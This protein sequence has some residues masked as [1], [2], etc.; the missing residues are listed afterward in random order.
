MCQKPFYEWNIGYYIEQSYNT[1][2]KLRITG[3]TTQN[4]NIVNLCVPGQLSRNLRPSFSS[5]ISCCCFCC[6]FRCGR[7]Y[8]WTGI[9][10]GPSVHSPGEMMLIGENKKTTWR[11]F[12]PSATLSTINPTWTDRGANPDHRGERPATNRLRQF[13]SLCIFPP[14]QF[15]F[16]F[17][18]NVFCL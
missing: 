3:V 15:Y 7:L 13:Q 14:T 12:Y 10:N 16:L 6:S 4:N 17:V 8:L 11:K 9:I 2:C 18:L 1:E 5:S